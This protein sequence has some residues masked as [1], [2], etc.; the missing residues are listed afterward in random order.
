MTCPQ[1]NIAA[2]L[3][4]C[5]QL[6]GVD[7]AT[8]GKLAAVVEPYL[9]ADGTRIWSLMQLERQRRPD[10]Y[11]RR[12]GGYLDRRHAPAADAAPIRATVG[13]FRGQ[14]TSSLDLPLGPGIAL[15]T[16]PG[17]GGAMAH[18]TRSWFAA[19][20]RRST[21]PMWRPSD[22][23]FATR[24]SSTSRAAARSQ[25]TMKASTRCSA[26][27]DPRRAVWWDLPGQPP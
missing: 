13:S 2:P 22:K 6:L 17:K 21:T 3:E 24:R 18:P 5:A 12:R 11:R 26:F 7:L 23:L 16:S 10:A 25:A 15:P 14:V 8:V 19:A 27:R 4:R 9:R 20:M 1:T